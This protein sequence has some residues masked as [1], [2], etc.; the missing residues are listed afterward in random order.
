MKTMIVG[1]TLAFALAWGAV[2][3][4]TPECNHPGRGGDCYDHR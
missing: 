2:I 4:L 3:V 1:L